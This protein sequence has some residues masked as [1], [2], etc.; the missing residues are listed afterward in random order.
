MKAHELN[1][2]RFK[3]GTTITISFNIDY[4]ARELLDQIAPGRHKGTMISR[5]IYEF[6]AREEGR[7]EALAEMAQGGQRAPIP[8]REGSPRSD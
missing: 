4:A 6:V 3:Q 7:K 1:Q 8:V 2:R 5:L